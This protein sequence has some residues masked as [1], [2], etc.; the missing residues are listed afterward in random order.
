MI[1]A[2]A[3]VL[4]VTATSTVRTNQKTLVAGVTVVGGT[5]ADG[6]VLYNDTAA[7]AAQ[8]K[9]QVTGGATEHYTYPIKFDSLHVTLGTGATEVLIYIV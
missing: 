9:A 3:K 2:E 8:K 7:T 5:A 4:R 6:A 1:D